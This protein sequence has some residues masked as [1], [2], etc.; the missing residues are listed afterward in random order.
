MRRRELLAGIGGA[1]VVGVSGYLAL[2]SEDGGPTGGDRR[3]LE[4][5]DVETFE[6]TH[7]PGET[8]SVP[9]DGSVTVIDLFA[10]WCQPCKPALEELQAVHENSTDVQFVSVTNEVLG[11]DLSRAD[12]IAWWEEFGG[13][14]PVGHDPDGTLLARLGTSALP[15]TAVADPDGRIVWAEKGVPDAQRVTEAIA[16]GRA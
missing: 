9:V 10:T 5:V 4:S 15:Y 1:A 7:T 11:G 14:W 3:R 13:P 12:V 6:T 2:S 16:T 8:V